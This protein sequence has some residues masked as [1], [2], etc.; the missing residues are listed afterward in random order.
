MFSSFKEAHD[1]VRAQRIELVDL[2]YCDLWGHLHHVT[3]STREFTN[4]GMTEG[5]G[6]DGS[7]WV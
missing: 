6:F 3:L 5:V 4:D 1:F 7:T 2:L